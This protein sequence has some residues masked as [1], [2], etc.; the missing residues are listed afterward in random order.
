[1][2]VKVYYALLFDVNILFSRKKICWIIPILGHFPIVFKCLS[3]QQLV[4]VL[5]VQNKT[6]AIPAIAPKSNCNFC[7]SIDAYVICCSWS[8]SHSSLFLRCNG[9]PNRDSLANLKKA[10][11]FLVLIYLIFRWINTYFYKKTNSI[12]WMAQK[13]KK[14][15]LRHPHRQINCIFIVT[16]QLLD[17]PIFL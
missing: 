1:M 17:N 10:H 3:R 9:R 8:I 16:S 12:R 4:V 14:I 11:K 2:M 15:W 13:M 5:L 7:I 6:K